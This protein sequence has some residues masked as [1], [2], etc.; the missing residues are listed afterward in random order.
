MERLLA[1]PTRRLDIILGYMIGLG[2]FALVQ[3]AVILGFTV[4]VLRINYLGSL[5]LLF[6]VVTLLAIVGVS[7]G[8]LAPAFAR[9]KFQV[10]Q[11][12]PLLI[13]PQALLGD[14]FWSVEEMPIHLQLAAQLM[15]I[16]YANR[17]LRDVMLRDFGIVEIWPNLVALLAFAAVLIALGSLTM[18]R[19]VE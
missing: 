19:E 15:P 12:I 10:A 7:L 14:P 18:G 2:L 17:A 5:S 1:T 8:I 4:A 9:N 3:V 16:T 11:F 6:L 13:I